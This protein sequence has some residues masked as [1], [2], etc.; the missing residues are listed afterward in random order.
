M[1]RMMR[2]E[3]KVMGESCKLAACSP[4]DCATLWPSPRYS[5]ARD[6]FRRVSQACRS[7]G[8]AASRQ[9]EQWCA[10]WG[11]FAAFQALYPWMTI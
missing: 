11:W 5:R 1:M 9:W 4:L 2:Q 7:L 8:T 3:A 10:A 6:P